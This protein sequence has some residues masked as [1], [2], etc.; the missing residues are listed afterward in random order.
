M[1]TDL[2]P[3]LADYNRWMNGKLYDAAAQLPPGEV[4]RD[5][6]AFF[7]SIHGTLEH[8]V[9]A[10]TL[11]LKRFRSHPAGAGLAAID[12]IVTPTALDQ[13]QFGTLAE[14]R[15]RRDLLDG[16]I[17]AWIGGLA[18]ADLDTPLTYRRFNGE[19]HTKP[20]RPTLLHFFNHQ[21]HH[22]GQTTT[23]LT[24]A[25]VDVGVTD[26]LVRVPEVEPKG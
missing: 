3:M 23:L 11:W 2:F 1:Q 26:L 15:A 14:M 9:V 12:A 7:G 6:G 4:D 18:A 22:R 8:L 17:V 13:R 16:L 25:G 10:D 24:Q 20:V 21:T 5:R 19:A